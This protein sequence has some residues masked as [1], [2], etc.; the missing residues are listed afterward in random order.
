MYN[1][2]TIVQIIHSLCILIMPKTKKQNLTSAIEVAAPR[3]NVQIT[4][5]EGITLQAP[6]GTT[7]EKFFEFAETQFPHL[8]PTAFIAGIINGKL[9]ELGYTLYHDAVVQPILYAD[10][11]GRRI[12][13]RTLVLLLAVAVDECFPGAKVN[14]SYAMPEGGFYVLVKNH[15]PFTESELKKLE[16]HMRKL[17][18]EDHPI[19]KAMAKTSDAAALFSERDED[20]KV[21][22]LEARHRPDLTLYTLR[23]RS[24]YHFGYMMP[25]TG[26]L[27]A[28]SLQKLDNGFIL[29][30]PSREKPDVPTPDIAENLKI[31]QVF[32]RAEEWL[33]RIGVEDIGQLNQLTRRHETQELVLAAE[34]RHEQHLALI[35][36]EIYHEHHQNNLRIVLIAGPSSSGKTTF[37]KRLAIQLLAHGLRPFTL[38]LDNYFVD[39]ELT[40]KDEHGNYDFE[41]L[42]AINLPLFNSHLLKLIQGEVV[43]L[44]TFDFISG[45]SQQQGSVSQLKDNQIL[46]CEGIHGI[47]P[48]LVTEIPTAQV[49]RIYVSPLTQLNLDLHNRIP[50]TDV[51]LLRRMCRDAV[52]RGYSATDTINRWASVR[53][54]EKR[55]IFPFQENANAMFNSSLVYELAALRSIAEPLLLQV[56][57]S[58]PAHLEANRLL[59]F[60]RWVHPMSETER[61]LIPDTSLLREFTGGSILDK[62]HPGVLKTRDI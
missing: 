7:L 18:K 8:F 16:K 10:S 26:Y 56:A 53:R 41:A 1:G 2:N 12:Y 20:D 42:E 32:Q 13:R 36:G 34:A 48:R 46:I 31:H 58:T 22:L 51:R 49:F 45:K 61:A 3:E 60:L 14:V 39:R 23:G 9:R 57:P 50:T 54:G 44:P 55:N 62:Y 21:R 5:Q 35:A 24:D 40:P 28:F 30:Y 27:K 19:T 15:A 59:S 4:L 29:H 25:S 38:E 33:E 47:N 37:S 17:V 43:Q 11:D 52:H 6:M